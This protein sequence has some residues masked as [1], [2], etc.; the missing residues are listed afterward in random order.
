MVAKKT[1]CMENWIVDLAEG[2]PPQE[3]RG[4]ENQ[5]TMGSHAILRVDLKTEGKTLRR[6]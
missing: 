4:G 6:S 3:R 1:V 5:L 2:S